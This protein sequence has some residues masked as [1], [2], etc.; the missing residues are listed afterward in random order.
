MSTVVDTLSGVLD[1]LHVTYAVLGG[2]ACQIPQR[3]T[4]DIPSKLMASICTLGLDVPFHWLLSSN[5]NR[6]AINKRPS[7]SLIV[8]D[9]Y[10]AYTSE[11]AAV[12]G[13]RQ[14]LHPF[15]GQARLLNWMPF[16]MC[17]L[18]QLFC[19]IQSHSMSSI[20]KRLKAAAEAV[21]QLYF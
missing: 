1:Q 11:T 8:V 18:F 9:I 10:G 3:N 19:S 16:G 13:A 2:V 5:K 6:R 4:Q 20:R 17:N 7:D 12:I 21:P 15:D 14:R